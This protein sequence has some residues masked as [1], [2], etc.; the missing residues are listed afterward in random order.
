VQIRRRRW[1]WKREEQN[2]LQTLPR[3]RLF[4]RFREAD[5]GRASTAAPRRCFI[6]HETSRQP[7]GVPDRTG[8][9]SSA[10]SCESFGRLRSAAS[11]A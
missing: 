5:S 3:R 6:A 4:S 10:L 7:E 1:A 2:V 11:S 9:V 8:M